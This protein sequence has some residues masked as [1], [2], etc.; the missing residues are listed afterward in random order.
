MRR[1]VLIISI[2]AFTINVNAQTWQWSRNTGGVDDEL[3][4]GVIT[5][6][7]GNVYVVGSYN[8]STIQ[9]GN[10]TALINNSGGFYNDLYIVK[11]NSQG[12][13]LWS[14]GIGGTDDEFASSITCDA[15]A[16]IYVTG[17]Y[18]SP[19]IQFGN[20]PTITNTGTD[21]IFI[22]KYDSSGNA[23]WSRSAGSTFA[24]YFYYGSSSITCDANA[25]LYITGS[26]S[27]TIQFGNTPAL[28]NTG[29]DN[30]FIAKYDSS[31]N[32]I[33]SR[34]AI[35]NASDYAYGI[36]CDANANIYITGNFSS[37]NT[38]FGSTPALVNN[39]FDNVFL[40][41]YDSTGNA[42]W[43]RSAAGNA[44]DESRGVVTDASGNIYIAGM[45]GSTSIQFGNTPILLNN[46][47]G[48]FAFI[49]KYD[50]L[51]NAI[52]SR[53][54][55]GVS[56]NGVPWDETY[57]IAA[58]PTGIYVA[59][60]FGSDTI[61][62][63]NTPPLANDTNA[64]PIGSDIFVAKYDTSGNAVW[65]QRAGGGAWD[66]ARGI[67]ADINGNVYVA[68]II[69]SDTTQFGTNPPLINNGYSGS[70]N[71]FIYDMFIA[72]YGTCI[73]IIP[74]SVSANPALVCQGSSTLSFIGGS[75]ASGAT[76]SWY[77]GS[78]GGTFV[79]TGITLVS[80]PTITNT[81]Y[82]RAEGA[83]NTT[84]CL[85][86]TLTYN[87][88]SIT[89]TSATYSP[90]DICTGTTITLSS[91]GGSLGTSA[92]WN[93]YIGSCGGTIAGTGNSISLTPSITTM[94]YL[95]AEGSCNT[96]SCVSTNVVLLV[97]STVPTSVSASPSTIIQGNST[98]LSQTGG[99][100]GDVADWNWFTGSC[101]GTLVGASNPLTQS[102]TVTTTYY[103]R[104]EGYC[105]TTTCLSITVTV[106]PTSISLVNAD[107]NI[108]I[109]PNPS[110]S[111]IT[112]KTIEISS[113]IRI[114]NISGD[115]LKEEKLKGNENIIDIKAL[116]KGVY[117]IDI[118]S[119][120]NISH[121]KIIK[122]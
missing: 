25:N 28:T 19:T 47:W 110:N 38:Q 2:L 122:K 68:G 67:A 40:A 80:T 23:I 119:D 105:N 78:C 66:E 5:D 89:A 88:P 11:Y 41:K 8:S 64:S 58:D 70:N 98:T 6:L 99:I 42:I 116:S 22:A 27:S 7:S 53:S 46:S 73:S 12:T 51:G 36:A 9:F 75:I 34:S 97:S 1:I 100:L 26:F 91:T 65:S 118:I 106:T 87:I 86:V 81:Y 61:Q 56:L 14:R 16:N 114:Y 44:S 3:A 54:S 92:I 37:T 13:V 117:I 55:V 71:W 111:L 72:K 45:F 59:G 4:Q 50:A 112:I 95:R 62:F 69:S 115:L 10:T 52:W 79:G 60:Y 77:S 18:N 30:V 63:G 39:G 32:A 76:W 107:D 102:P 15:N 21:N 20:T 49:A 48:Y 82:I 33:W 101:G 104:A 74:T 24:G 31:G 57:S 83:C 85:S 90:M 108:I 84:S 43:A 35:G 17:Y 96:T 109:Y 29:T 121:Y 113:I 94:Y 93:W 103:I 120:K